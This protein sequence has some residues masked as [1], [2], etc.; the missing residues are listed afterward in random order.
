M[1]SFDSAPDH[2]LQTKLYPP[3]VPDRLVRRQG[4]L[5][6][7]QQRRERPV[8][9]VSAPAGYGKSTLVAQWL[10]SCGESCAWLSLDEYDNGLV[11]VL[12]YI[13][14]AMQTVFSE[15]GPETELLLL[16]PKF[17]FLFPN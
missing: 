17:Y 14:A 6:R 1:T 16:L 2:L 9:L 12:A 10:G 13:I 4:L 5:D 8:T 15:F 3:R 11:T 7:L